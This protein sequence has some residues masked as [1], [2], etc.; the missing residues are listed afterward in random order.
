MKKS[1]F[2]NV[3]I[4]SICWGAAGLFFVWLKPYGFAPIQMTAIRGTV[5]AFFM[6]VYLMLFDRSKFNFSKKDFPLLLGSGISLFGTSA[7]YYLSMDASSIATA[8]ILM[9]TAPVFVMIYSVSFFG[10]RFNVSKLI[11]IILMLVGCALVSGVIGGMEFKVMG[12]VYGLI[13]GI[14]YSAYN[15]FTKIQAIKNIHSFTGTFYSFVIMGFTALCIG[16]PVKMAENASINPLIVIPLIIGTGLLTCTTPFLLY[17]G[18]LK[19]MD[20][21]I[22]SSLSVIEPMAATVFS[23]VILNEKLKLP[24]ICGILLILIAVFLLSRTKKEG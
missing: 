11:S 19:Y 17:S 22:A 20:A 8:V 21:G 9:Y 1:A 10:E 7:F 18:A 2:I 13:S 24:T 16:N 3:V 15:I 6:L 12:I 5:S 14:M 23:V 4:A